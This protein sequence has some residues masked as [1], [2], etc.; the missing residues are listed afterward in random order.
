MR[1]DLGQKFDHACLALCLQTK[2]MS[3]KVRRLTPVVPL[4]L[5][6]FGFDPP[7]KATAEGEELCRKLADEDFARH[8]QRFDSR[9]A[10]A[11]QAK[12]IDEAHQ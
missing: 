9:F 8:W 11:L 7:D 4:N 1:W 3:Q 5:E 2:A 12:N 10:T 6:Q